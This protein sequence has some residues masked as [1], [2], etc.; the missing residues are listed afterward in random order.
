MF[1][2]NLLLYVILKVYGTRLRSITPMLRWTYGK[3]EVN[4]HLSTFNV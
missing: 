1:Q 4:H 3:R 2:T